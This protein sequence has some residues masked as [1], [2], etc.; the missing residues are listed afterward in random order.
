M[1][2]KPLPLTSAVH[3]SEAHARGRSSSLPA[4]VLH[5]LISTQPTLSSRPPPGP[6]GHTLGLRLSLRVRHRVT[7]PGSRTPW[8]ALVAV[9]A[10]YRRVWHEPPQVNGADGARGV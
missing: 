5:V 1:K 7:S 4:F 8:S 9:A 6:S 2:G 3:V 10:S